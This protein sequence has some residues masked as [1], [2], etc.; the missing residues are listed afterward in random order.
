M[1]INSQNWYTKKQKY[2]E[3]FLSNWKGLKIFW[4]ITFENDSLIKI[5]ENKTN[6]IYRI[7]DFI[8]IIE[9]EKNMKSNNLF[10]NIEDEKF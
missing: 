3:I 1:N 7:K 6:K 8:N 9:S 4:E 2:F 10:E 5:K